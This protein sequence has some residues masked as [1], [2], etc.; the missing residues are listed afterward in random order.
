VSRHRI[1]NARIENY[2]P[3]LIEPHR[4][5]SR[6]GNTSALHRHYIRINGET[7]NFRALGSQQWV[8][9]SDRVSFNYEDNGGYKTILKATLR[10]IDIHGHHVVRGIRGFKPTLRS[11]SSRLPVSRRETRD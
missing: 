1:D 3:A 10:T 2:R 11:A 7:Y 6:G 4:P 9:K 8:F 5:P